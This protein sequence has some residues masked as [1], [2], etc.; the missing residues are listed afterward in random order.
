MDSEKKKLSRDFLVAIAP[1]RIRDQLEHLRSVVRS[2]NNT[3]HLKTS[4]DTSVI[5]VLGCPSILSA[6]SSILPA[7]AHCISEPEELNELGPDS[8]ISFG[9]VVDHW[10]DESERLA[11]LRAKFQAGGLADV[12]IYRLFNDF[13]SAALAKTPVADPFQLG[14]TINWREYTIFA[15]VCTGRSGSTY[16]CDLLANTGLCGNPTEHLREPLLY[17]INHDLIDLEKVIVTMI[18]H[19]SSPNKVFGTKL[20]SRFVLQLLADS[21]GL[22][23][24]QW[25]SRIKI[26]CLSRHDKIAQATSIARAKK[27]GTWH[28]AGRKDGLVRSMFNR[29]KK[30]QSLTEQELGTAVDEYFLNVERQETLDNYV[31]RLFDP[32]Q[33]LSLEYESLIRN[34]EEHVSRIFQHLGIEFDQRSLMLQSRYRKITTKDNFYQQI[35]DA[36]VKDVRYTST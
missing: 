2:G 26:I 12:P 14:A 19:H 30:P 28:E 8:Q 36:V 25:L 16:L 18:L 4:E 1:L 24:N 15:I 21:P 9:L 13:I 35:K 3:P 6:I 10:I 33:V 22:K 29:W 31:D 5:V 20:I 17:C 27:T 32:N 23:K 7:N 11:S 34:P